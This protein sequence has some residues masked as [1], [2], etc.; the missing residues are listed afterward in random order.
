MRH[1][2]KTLPRWPMLAALTATLCGA[3]PAGAHE[4]WFAQR[5]GKLAL[6][7]GAGAHDLD[8]VKR[9]PKIVSTQA[10]DAEGRVLPAELKAT[11]SLVLVDVPPEADRVMAMMDNGLWSK[12]PDGKFHNKGRDDLPDAVVSGRY[13]KHATHLRKLPAG[14]LAPVPGMK[15]QLVPVGK[16]FPTKMGELL[17]VQVLFEGKP[18]AGVKVYQDAVT[19]PGGA[20]VRTGR[21][22]RASLKVR[23]GGL[24][25]VL[26]E[27]Q[28]PPENPAQTLMTEHV[29]TLSFMY[30]PPPE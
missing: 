6:I 25:V 8:M 18:V 5:S 10:L 26:A 14:A 1:Q 2:R 27:F 13:Y 11:D 17:T 21:D 4:I 23:N 7:Y 28:A 24:N 3:L 19:D 29:G 20:H 15:F 9:L 22:G 30:D 16:T 12:S